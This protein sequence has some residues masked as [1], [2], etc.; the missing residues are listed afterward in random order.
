MNVEI[1]DSKEALG[2]KAAADGAELIRAAIRRRGKANVVVASGASQ[3]AMLDNLVAAE[4]VAWHAVSGFHLDEYIGL[5]ITHPASFRLY[6]WQRFV[7]RLPLPLR[8]F[9]YIDADHDPEAERLR[10]SRI[11]AK[12]IL[13]V[14]FVG[15]G[16]NGHLAFNEPPADFCV[17]DPYLVIELTEASRRQ[18]V[19]EGWFASIDEVPR[20]AISMSI[21][22]VMRA[23]AIVCAV[24]DRRKAEAV[25][26]A[27]EGPVTPD[28]PASILQRHP[29]ATI[30]LE[31]ESASLLRGE[32]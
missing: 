17:T 29:R 3:I 22:R 31:P 24:P 12:R 2:A 8:S 25:R 26:A 14:A 32:S 19:G 20:R 21:D 28:V 7:R 13:D 16:E 18:Q 10:L 6:M 1:L 15:I 11:I 23:K 4:D 30:Y 27:V 5:P 9:H